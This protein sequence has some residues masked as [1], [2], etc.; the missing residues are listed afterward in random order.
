MSGADCIV[1]VAATGSNIILGE[2]HQVTVGFNDVKDKLAPVSAVVGLAGF[3]A[4]ETGEQLSYIGD[5]LLDWFYEG[6]VM[7]VQVDKRDVTARIFDS[8]GAEALRSALEVAGFVFPETTKTLAELMEEMKPGPDAALT[9]LDA[10][11]SQMATWESAVGLAPEPPSE[12]ETQPV[13][14]NIFGRYSVVSTVIGAEDE[15]A[16]TSVASLTDLGQGKVQ[17]LTLDDDEEEPIIMSYDA[18]TRK[19]YYYEEG[20]SFDATFTSTEGKVT[21]KG[22]ISGALWGERYEATMSLTKISD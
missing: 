10:L 20:F 18:A 14:V 8:A 13:E 16:Q 9:A 6:K 17:W 21:G 1:D 4:A 2:N 7:G 11:V 3:N 5:T 22:Y 19:V 15:D 12:P